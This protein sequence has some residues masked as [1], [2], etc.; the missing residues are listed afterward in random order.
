MCPKALTTLALRQIAFPQPQPEQS[1][2]MDCISPLPLN[3]RTHKSQFQAKAA[4]WD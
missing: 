2:L 3:T 1:S 4:G